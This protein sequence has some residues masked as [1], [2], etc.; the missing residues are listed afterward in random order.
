[1][2]D[3]HLLGLTFILMHEMDAVRCKEWRIFPGL[4]FLN[5]KVGLFLFVF[6]H[7]PLFYWVMMETQ[8]G[9]ENFRIG[10]N[11]FLIIHLI[12]HL[13]FLL[14]KKNEFK[15]WISWVIIFGASL[16]GLLDIMFT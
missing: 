4:S 10:I 8:A 6:L 11:Y 9:N 5:D 14:H 15:D 3:F 12:L 13:L 16:F 7:I 1:M 2:I